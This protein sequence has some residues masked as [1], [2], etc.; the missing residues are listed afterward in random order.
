MLLFAN[1]ARTTL[2]AAVTTAAGQVATV[3]AGAGALFVGV[4]GVATSTTNP[5]R[6][7]MTAVDAAGNDTG[8]FE[9]VEVVRSGDNLTLQS[10]ALEG[11]TA[12]AWGVGTVIECRDT[13]DTTRLRVSGVA[14]RGGAPAYFT[15]RY[16]DGSLVV[17]TY[18]N[19]VGPWDTLNATPFLC[20]ADHTF[21]AIGTY[22]ITAAP[23]GSTMSFG[24]YQADPATGL[25]GALVLDTATTLL[26]DTAG[27]KE[28]VIS[29]PLMAGQLY[30]LV[31]QVQTTNMTISGYSGSF[32]N[33][34]GA[35]SAQASGASQPNTTLSATATYGALAANGTTYNWYG[36]GGMA[37]M[38]LWLKA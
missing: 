15:G 3:Q 22:V 18:S 34:A 17:G 27:I 37:A 10:R 38:L 21:V 29:A 33:A 12:T 7:V 24:I 2:T 11:T 6:C 4:G 8:A 26:A 14:R 32:A 30:W 36:T 35:A 9:V 31:I 16:Y 28:V 1:K 25:P 5:M 23:A 20:T 19:Y 13:A